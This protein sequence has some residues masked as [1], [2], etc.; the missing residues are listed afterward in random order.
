[1]IEYIL[2]FPFLFFFVLFSFFFFYLHAFFLFLIYNL[3]IFFWLWF[4]LFSISFPPSFFPFYFQTPVFFYLKQPP[5]IK[6]SSPVYCM[7]CRANPL[8]RLIGRYLYCWWLYYW[9]IGAVFDTVVVVGVDFV[10][11][12]FVLDDLM[13]SLYNSTHLSYYLSYSYY[14]WYV[15]NGSSFCHAYDIIIN[16]YGSKITIFTT[17]LTRVSILISILISTL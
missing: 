6:A 2:I 5:P 4:S 15:Y 14:Y 1:M 13:A 9:C 7:S 8:S 17:L 11:W 16:T 10:L 12:L 3:L